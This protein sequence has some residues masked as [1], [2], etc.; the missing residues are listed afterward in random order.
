MGRFA[1]TPTS[2]PGNHRMPR[3]ATRRSKLIH[4]RRSRRPTD[5]NPPGPSM[6][7]KCEIRARFAGKTRRLPRMEQCLH[8]LSLMIDYNP[9][10]TVVVA[11]R[12]KFADGVLA[13]VSATVLVAG[14]AAVDTRVRD[15]IAGFL[16]GDPVRSVAQGLER[17]QRFEIG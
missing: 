10:E 2:R 17:S 15:L 9:R 5:A 13:A 16:R 14:L 12:S 4:R 8:C 3:L 6:V 11:R 1:P 7:P